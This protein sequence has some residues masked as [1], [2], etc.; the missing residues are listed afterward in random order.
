MGVVPLET[1]LSVTDKTLATVVLF[2]C[3]VVSDVDKD[4]SAGTLL[5][6][7]VQEKVKFNLLSMATFTKHERL[8]VLYGTVS[9]RVRKTGAI[10][11]QKS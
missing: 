1:F 2:E 4:V 9:S 10:A 7:S 8:N 6:C 11:K 3:R 5:D